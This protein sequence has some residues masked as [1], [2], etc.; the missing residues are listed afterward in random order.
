MRMDIAFS[1]SGRGGGRLLIHWL[2]KKMTSENCFTTPLPASNLYRAISP[3]RAAALYRIDHPP[4]PVAEQIRQVA[5][6]LG[7]GDEVPAAGG[8]SVVIQP[9][10]KDQV[11]GDCEEKSKSRPG[12]FVSIAAH[13]VVI[14]QSGER[15]T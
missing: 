1:I 7:M 12:V 4:R 8:V 13:V 10:A 5:D 15:R 3:P 11:C 14:H 6:R 2:Q 9:R